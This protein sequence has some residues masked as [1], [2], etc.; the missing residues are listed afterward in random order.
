M[1]TYQKIDFWKTR[2]FINDEMDIDIQISIAENLHFAKDILLCKKITSGN[3]MEFYHEV[4][5]VLYPTIVYYTKIK[6]D[7]TYNGKNV[8]HEFINF[9]EMYLRLKYDMNKYNDD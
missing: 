5:L 6:K 8:V 2:G 4:E 3:A 7:L 9:C 1:L